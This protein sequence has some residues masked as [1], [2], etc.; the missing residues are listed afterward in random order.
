MRYEDLAPKIQELKRQN[1]NEE[2]LALLYKWIDATELDV[3]RKGGA[4]ESWPYLQACVVLRKLKRFDDE[5]GVIERFLGQPSSGSKQ[6]QELMERLGKAYHLAG[7]TE[8]RQEDGQSVT[9]YKPESIPLDER[10]I[11]VR[12]AVLVDTETTGLSQADEL[13]E[14]AIVRFRYSHFSGRILAVTD[15][16][17]GRREPNCEISA[18]AAKVHGLTKTD[19]AGRR[20]DERRI[21]AILD[22]ASMVFAHNASFDRRMTA[23][24]PG[25]ARSPWYCTMN[26]IDWLGKGCASRKLDDACRKFGIPREGHSA[27]ADIDALLRL[28][29]TPDPATGSPLLSEMTRSFPIGYVSSWQAQLGNDDDD[30]DD[31]GYVG[32][33]VITLNVRSDG[34]LHLD[35]G[36]R[37]QPNKP[38]APP[39]PA[40]V[41]VSVP[42]TPA[43]PPEARSGVRVLVTILL[44]LVTLFAIVLMF[45][46]A[47]R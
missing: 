9:I 5:V 33:V 29:A 44:V 25:F 38:M 28:L 32:E 3:T 20:L 15:R 43:Q 30:D 36:Q 14:L 47:L 27:A 11:F 22:G 7:L 26:G 19:V 17:V 6:S 8:V 23:I 16:Y 4:V 45:A 42:A 10:P 34:S 41:P 12:D 40:P 13:I 35:D 24:L 18:Q 2:A 37:Q 31:D 1:R 21:N 39:N 46:Y